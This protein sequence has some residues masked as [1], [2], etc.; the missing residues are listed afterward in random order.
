MKQT[1]LFCLG[2]FALAGQSAFG[3]E[4]EM[5]DVA[6]QLAAD[7]RRKNPGLD[8]RATLAV[9]KF[10]TG[11]ARLESKGTAGLIR[12]AFQKEFLRSV[13]FEVIERENLEKLTSEIE[14]KQKGLTQGGNA[15][16]T[17]KTAEYLLLGELSEDGQTL[18]VSARLVQASSGAVVSAATTR[19]ALGD[20]ERAADDFR[21]NA[22]QSQYGITLGVDGSLV[23][24][25]GETATS[26]AMV[27]AFIAY[28]I[29]RPLRLGAGLTYLQWNEFIREEAVIGAGKTYR[30]YALGGMGPR[31]FA[32]F[33]MSPHPRWNV[34]LRADAVF[35]PGIKLE[36][37]VSDMKIWEFNA[38][39]G[40]PTLAGRRVL[41]TGYS[42]NGMI[43]FKPA[44]LVEFLISRR[45]SVFASGGYM[46]STVF[47]PFV[48]ESAGYRQWAENA[49]INGTFAQYQNYNFNRRPN[50]SEVQMQM[51]FVFF[52]VGL[53]LH[54]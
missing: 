19:V 30:N 26:P 15:D 47:K 34:G 24:P 10:R 7:F 50:G 25:R 4:R 52:D 33:L 35:L 28:R 42:N 3:Y 2:L 36:Q 6:K 14:L 13:Y 43:I 16:D 53:S 18:T 21:Y 40:T 51:G 23:Q 46:F 37:D 11:S 49:D 22:F 27:T 20:T 29:A 41:V 5:A 8:F 9:A 31:I 45:L 1:I 32:D 48:Y 17:L 54:F 39:S 12:D 44:L 38:T